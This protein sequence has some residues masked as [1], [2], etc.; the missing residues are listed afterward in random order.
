MLLPSLLWL[1]LFLPNLT[2]AADPPRPRP[3]NVSTAAPRTPEEEQRAFHLPEGFEIELVAA[4]PDIRKPLN[5]AFD[6]RGRL[7]VTDTVE[8]PFP[9]AAGSTPRDGVKILEDFQPNGRAATVRTFADGL[10]IPIGILP[11]PST[12]AALV[13]SIPD[14]LRLEDTDGDGRADRRDSLYATF[15][16]KDTHGMTNAFTWGFDGWIY[17]THGF[18]N[19]STVAGSDHTAITMKS[20]NVYRMRPEGTHLEYITHG[21]VNPFGLAFD[22]LG[23]LYSSDCHSRP[24]YQLLRGAW[25]PS[26]GA[27]HDG[28]GFGPEMMQHNHGS[29]A[30]AGIVHVS[31]DSF[32]EAYNGTILIGNVVTNRINHDRLEWHGSSP[33]AI[34]QPDFLWSEDNWFRPVDLKLGPD[35]ALYVAD[36]YNR[37]IGHYEVPLTHPGRDRERGRIWRIVYRG[38]LSRNQPVARRAGRLDAARDDLIADL[39]HPSLA[40]RQS[41]ANQLA[42]RPPDAKADASLALVANQDQNPWRRIHALWVL[43]RRGMLDEPT[44]KAAAGAGDRALRVHAQRL[45]GEGPDLAGSRRS[46]VL[47]GLSD[48]DPLVRRCAAEAL[49][50]HPDVAFIRPL[51]DLRQADL[52]DDTHLLHVVRMALRDQFRSEAAWAALEAGS[53]SERDRTDVADVATG[54]PSAAAAAFLLGQ[55]RRQEYPGSQADGYVH[56]VA[57]YGAEGTEHELIALLA[58]QRTAGRPRQAVLLTAAQKGIAERG[59]QPAA[60]TR[61]L[62]TEVATA[63]LGSSRGSEMTAGI[64]LASTFKLKELNGRLAAVARDRKADTAGRIAAMTALGTLVPGAALP[65]LSQ[66]LGDSSES[67]ELREKAIGTLGG[68][69][70][71]TADAALVT[72][73]PT[74]PGRLQS[75][76]AAGLAGRPAGARALLDAVAAGKASARV[77]QEPRIVAMLG[78]SKLPDLK[79]RLAG[80]LKGLPPAD[81]RV[82]DLLAERRR[83]FDASA[84][85]PQRG[86]QVFEKICAACH[87]IQ[88]EGARIGPQLDG[89]G[90]RGPDRILED[91]LDPSR[92]VDQA[93]RTT[94]LALTDGRIVSGLLLREE[95]VVLVLADSQGKE[96]RVANDQVDE[97][98]VSQLSPMPANFTEQ[99]EEDEFYDLIAFLLAPPPR[100]ESPKEAADPTR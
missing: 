59:G 20:G 99:I 25:Y 3:E 64:Q 82:R 48:R 85:D 52:A 76:I 5:I 79:E 4:E 47:A 9:A 17:A 90:A 32:P 73:L 74:V 71:P 24:I 54:V 61:S 21:Q 67:F 62:A 19:T 1:F 78:Q 42:A 83:R 50:R 44:L 11:L 69:N 37:I 49:G 12:R 45:L 38:P 7:W 58:G 51:L 98:S 100:K 94:Q 55:L 36:F 95:G 93:F 84:R 70:R 56:H 88:G 80:L 8:Y 68:L 63:L 15:G 6:D 91:V 46:L 89:I 40:V 81:D 27:P 60:E 53:W 65:V 16:F 87:Q 92:N 26:F 75:A 22:P 77:L 13:Y 66:I 72:V 29:T 23:N 33:K 97:R 28:L 30:I 86:A 43:Q 14:I 2:V 10:N 57:R 41:A 31:G 96:V 34:E 18:S 39:G 35:G